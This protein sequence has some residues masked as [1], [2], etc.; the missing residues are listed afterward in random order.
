[1]TIM[2]GKMGSTALAVAF[3]L[4]LTL[5]TAWA[6]QSQGTDQSSETAN[7]SQDSSQSQSSGQQQ[8]PQQSSQSA[9][10]SGGTSNDGQANALVAT[11]GGAE[12]RGSDVL[13]VIGMLPPQLQSQSPD[14]LVPIALEQLIM[15]ELILEKARSQNLAEDPEVVSL[16]T[17][18]TQAAE[19]DAMVQVWLDRELAK[20][21]TDE[22]IQ[23]S[24]DEA[25]QGQKD[26][27]PLEA[28]R[29]QIEQH[30]RRQALEELRTQLREGAD[31][32]LYDPTGKPVE[33]S[34]SGSQSSETSSSGNTTNGQSIDAAKNQA[35]QSGMQGVE[36]VQGATILKGK[37]STNADVYMIVGPSGELLALAA[38]LP[39]DSGA[40]TG[41]TES[42]DGSEAATE[43]GEPAESGFMATQAQPASPQM[44]DPSSVEQG[45][46]QLELGTRG[47]AGEV[48]KP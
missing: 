34:S 20:T 48:S 33:G 42:Q 46:R 26:F 9:G 1:M 8:T 23:K 21:V 36:P 12:I 35:E 19:K 15:R 39:A 47:A 4:P 17:G 29:P 30:L 28:V 7:Q 10:S 11:V 25:Q 16:V 5:G 32:V 41:S 18:S 22:A 31:I 3:A 44:W 13:T 37:A 38:P 27:P 6:Q 43:A 2:N 40:K 14:M 24:Y 45:M